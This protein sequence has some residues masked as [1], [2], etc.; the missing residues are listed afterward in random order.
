GDRLELATVLGDLGRAAQLVGDQ[1]G[2]RAWIGKALDLADRCGALPLRQRLTDDGTDEATDIARL[3][4]KAHRLQELSA[5]ERRV[6]ELASKGRRNKDIAQGLGI[7]IST[8]EQHLTR[9]YRKLNV[10]RR[11]DLRYVLGGASS[12]DPALDHAG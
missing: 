11:T 9:V 4:G 10:S 1:Q 12:D 6:A 3:V 7:T 2:S 8:V 5:A